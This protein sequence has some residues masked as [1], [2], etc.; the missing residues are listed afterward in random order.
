MDT[1]EAVDLI[2]TLP[3]GSLYRGSKSVAA[4]WS[5]QQ[6]EMAE[7]I[8]LLRLHAHQLHYRPEDYEA[9]RRPLDIK[10]E[11]DRAEQAKRI[12]DRLTD[13]N[14]EWVEVDGREIGNG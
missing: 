9:I 12:H 13:P 11:R 7:I 8:D 5:E 14:V 6:Y 3:M 10:R 4:Q 1:D 2:L